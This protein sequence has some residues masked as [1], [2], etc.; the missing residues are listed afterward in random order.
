MTVT[1]FYFIVALLPIMWIISIMW[2]RKWKHVLPYVLL[3]AL[4]V[5]IYL[6]VIFF[7]HL[8]L[9]DHDEYGLK[10]VFLFLFIIA[11]H[12]IIGFIFALYF[13]FRLSKK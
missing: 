4:A 6:F 5:F 9:F 2:L 7:A 11:F 10:K 13:K 8:K 3:N 1:I 12:T